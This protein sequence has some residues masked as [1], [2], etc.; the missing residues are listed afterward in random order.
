MTQ[1]VKPFRKP[2]RELPCSKRLHPT[3][4][5]FDE[6]YAPA[7]S[8][9]H[10]TQNTMEDVALSPSQPRPPSNLWA[11]MTHWMLW[12][13]F[14]MALMLLT[15]VIVLPRALGFGIPREPSRWHPAL[16]ALRNLL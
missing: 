1:N 11:R 15:V 8:M 9:T 4:D 6:R 5:Q 3:R 12:R 10:S 2:V 13:I 7:S 14:I 16:V